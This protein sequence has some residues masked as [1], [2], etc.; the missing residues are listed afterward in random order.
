MTR[1]LED[2][3]LEMRIAEEGCFGV[4]ADDIINTFEELLMSDDYL[5]EVYREHFRKP[6]VLQSNAMF[7]MANLLAFSALVALRRANGLPLPEGLT[8]EEEP[9]IFLADEE[10]TPVVS[11]EE[12]DFYVS[13]SCGEGKNDPALQE[14]CPTC[15]WISC[16]A[17]EPYGCL[18][19]TR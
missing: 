9:S 10:K 8:K 12:E 19:Y 3:Q 7:V 6:E 1:T 18:C 14:T 16:L 15:G 4:T 11:E 17:C 13:C 2:I 5:P